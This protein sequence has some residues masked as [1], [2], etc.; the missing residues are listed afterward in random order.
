MN[1][2]VFLR[3]LEFFNFIYTDMKANGEISQKNK[4]QLISTVFPNGELKSM[5]MATN[6]HQFYGR[7]IQFT[8]LILKQ[9]PFSQIRSHN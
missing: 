2:A 3:A 8:Q 7:L 6:S 9:G 4:R 1:S 5:S